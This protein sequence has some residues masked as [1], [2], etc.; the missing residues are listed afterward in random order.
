MRL[1]DNYTVLKNHVLEL[2]EYIPRYGS[3]DS[4]IIREEERR[5]RYHLKV[6]KNLASEMF[7]IIQERREDD[8]KEV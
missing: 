6:I 3:Y 4:K 8:R 5:A 1:S 7:N 2:Q